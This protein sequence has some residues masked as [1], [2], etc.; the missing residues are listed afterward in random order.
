MNDRIRAVL[1][2]RAIDDV[3][4]IAGPLR[5]QL[6]RQLRDGG[7]SDQAD[8]FDVFAVLDG[9][10]LVYRLRE[11]IQGYQLLPGQRPRKPIDLRHE[12]SGELW[13]VLYREMT[14]MERLDLGGEFAD[15]QH[16]VVAVLSNDEFYD[17][18]GIQGV[19]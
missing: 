6:F 2:G 4:N 13:W 15:A 3:W 12:A 5:E 17:K 7:L 1:A 14:S 18:A 19:F 8:G 16:V 10:F 9:R 11:A